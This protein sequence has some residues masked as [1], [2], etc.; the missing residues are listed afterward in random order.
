MND[1]RIDFMMMSD[2]FASKIWKGF[3]APD[4]VLEE[5]AKPP[6]PHLYVVNTAPTI[7]GGEHWCVLL[8]FKNECEFFDS[9]GRSPASYH[10]LHAFVEQCKKISFSET[11]FQS[12]TALTCGHHCIFYSMMRARGVSRK[13]IFEMYNKNDFSYNDDMVFNFVLRNFGSFMARIQTG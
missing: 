7:T 3:L 4:V 2:G 11:Q 8:V 1:K 5:A 9:F 13:K 10:L 6:F 12:D